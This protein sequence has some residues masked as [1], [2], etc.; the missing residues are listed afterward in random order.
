MPSINEY[1]SPEDA[2][3]YHLAEIYATFR[4][5]MRPETGPLTASETSICATL[6]S[7]G[8]KSSGIKAIGRS[9]GKESR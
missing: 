5:G 4:A 1:I 6:R 7:G 2:A 9:T 3:N 8:R